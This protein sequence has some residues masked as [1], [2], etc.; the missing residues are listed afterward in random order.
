MSFY[1]ETKIKAVRKARQCCGCCK[2]ID[3]G[4]PAVECASADSEGFWS[5]TYH[6]ECRAAECAYNELKDYRYGDDWWPL[7]E[8]EF[9]DWPWLIE[10]FPAVADRMGI[11]AEKYW[12]AVDRYAS[13]WKSKP[14][15]HQPKDQH[16][17]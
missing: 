12:Q 1:R 9:D 14:A 17:G 8:I 7:Y 3:V 6:A 10:D 4:A 16:H 5:G 2:T 13:V 11:T 15:E